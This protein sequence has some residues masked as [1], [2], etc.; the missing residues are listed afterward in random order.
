MGGIGWARVNAQEGD[1]PGDGQQSLV[2]PLAGPAIIIDHTCTDLSKIPAYWL[3]EAKKLTFHYAH[4]SHGSQI[5]TGLEYLEQQNASYGVAI[6]YGDTIELPAD[7]DSLRIYDGFPADTYIEPED[8]WASPT[9]INQT[10]TV[11]N[12]GLFDY[13]MWS[14]C[15]QQSSNSPQTVQEYLDTMTG[16]ESQYPAMRY[17]LMTGHTDG[18]SE[19]LTQN[20][21]AVREYARTHGMVLFDF[22]DI[23]SYD[24]AGNYYP[25][26]DDSCPW[27]SDWC[28]A[29]PGDCQNL[30]QSDSEC[31]HSHGF[32]CKIKGQAFWWLMARLAGWPGPEGTTE[33]QVSKSASTGGA[34]A[35]QT[36]DFRVVIRGHFT[37]T[38]TLTDEVP[39][40]L[41]YS[42]G[43]LAASTGSGTDDTDP[44]LLRWSGSM[45]QTNVVTLTYSA[46]VAT[47]TTTAVPGLVTVTAIGYTPL[48]T[49]HTLILNGFSEHL[50]V[51]M[52]H[53]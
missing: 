36:V 28:S 23:E 40:G 6:K 10:Q 34:A 51:I 49:T 2:G 43:S 37:S 45:S 31:A 29:H 8:Y 14:W 9:G 4:T 39:A 42:S 44:T 30:P 3:E 50:P 27:C 16:F 12:T 38:V 52:K 1:P 17:I 19:T 53:G 15:G 33:G 32:N 21:N 20:N 25:N 46:Q 48:S 18:G 47:T 7:P 13:S 24:P 26:T 41:T 22:A 35:G 5:E 11:A